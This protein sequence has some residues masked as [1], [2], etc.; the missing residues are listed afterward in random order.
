MRWQFT[1]A[2]LLSSLL[3][4][5]SCSSK[6]NSSEEQE[7]PVIGKKRVVTKQVDG[8]T[9]KD[10]V[11]HRVPPF[12]FVD[13]DSSVVTNKTF[14]DAI[15]VA[16]FFFTSCPTICPEM[17]E[18]MHKVYKAFKNNE[19]VKFLSHSVDPK[20][21]TPAALRNYANKLGVRSS[22]WKFVTG[23]MDSIYKVGKKGYMASMQEDEEAPGGFLHSGQFFLVDEQRR[24]RGIYRGTKEK[25][26]D[27]LIKDIRTLLNE[28]TVTS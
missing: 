20:R 14:D 7:L 19:R 18:H 22:K 27:K 24:I 8:K 26:V 25:S 10:T 13:Q 21:D 5:G 4:L 23:P 28:K 15:Y 6:Q 9:I 17:T 12:Q 3:I 16:D 2:A 11:Q 1:G